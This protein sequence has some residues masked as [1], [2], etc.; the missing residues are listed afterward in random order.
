VTLPV[1]LPFPHT[2][3]SFPTINYRPVMLHMA[4]EAPRYPFSLTLYTVYLVTPHHCQRAYYTFLR[5]PSDQT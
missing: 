4:N 1:N 5:G 2:A 3:E